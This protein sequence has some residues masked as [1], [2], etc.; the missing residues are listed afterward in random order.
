M[1]HKL[2]MKRHNSAMS[3][4]CDPLW[5]SIKDWQ[6]LPDIILGDIVMMLG[7]DKLKDILE[8]ILKCRQVCRSWNVM[9]AQMTKHKKHIIRRKAETLV[10]Q[11]REEWVPWGEERGKNIRF[12]TEVVTAASPAHHGLLDSVKRIYLQEVDLASVPSEHLASLASCVTD[13][14]IIIKVEN[15]DMITILDNVKTFLLGVCDQP[16]STEETQALVR[17]MESRVERVILG[18]VEEL[19]LDIAALTQYSGQGKCSLL[20]LV[21]NADKDT[22]YRKDLMRWMFKVHWAAYIDQRRII[23]LESNQNW[24]WD[25]GLDLGLRIWY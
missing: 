20:S 12:L 24:N 11:T 19:S 3:P 16:L 10:A 25:L 23:N 4:A 5:K 9:I 2:E 18:Y 14:L 7:M 8:D 13:S 22:K 21:P 6:N 17:A 1:S 15:C